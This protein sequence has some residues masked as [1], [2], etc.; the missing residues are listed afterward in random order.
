MKYI[1]D[2]AAQGDIMIIKETVLPEGLKAVDKGNDWF[3]DNDK[4]I[5]AHSETGHHHIIK[6]QPGVEL[7]AA[8]DNMTLWLVV[9]NP[10]ALIEHERSFHTHETIG[11][12]EGI[13][14]IHRQR[15]SDAMEN[16]RLAM[17]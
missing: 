3:Y 10:E 13:Y 6:D 12:E 7:Y 9:K 4:F 11:L 5:V 2:I 17:D 1:T 8:N 16:E 15:E 14:R